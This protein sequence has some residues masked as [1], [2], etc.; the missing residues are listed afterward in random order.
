MGPSAPAGTRSKRDKAKERAAVHPN[1]EFH[2]RTKAAWALPCRISGKPRN[3]L[4]L[5]KTN[6]PLLQ[7]ERRVGRSLLRR[8][9][10]GNAAL[11]ASWLVPKLRRSSLH[12]VALLCLHTSVVTREWCLR[13]TGRLGTRANRQRPLQASARPCCQTWQGRERA[14]WSSPADIVVRHADEWSRSER[15]PLRAEERFLGVGK[16]IQDTVK[17]PQLDLFRCSRLPP[18]P[19]L[20]RVLI[21]GWSWVSG[22]SG[23]V[24]PSW[25]R[26]SCDVQTLLARDDGLDAGSLVLGIDGAHDDTGDF[27]MPISNHLHRVH[28]TG[29]VCCISQLHGAPQTQ[30]SQSEWKGCCNLGGERDCSRIHCEQGAE[31]S[32]DLGVM[33]D[34]ESVRVFFSPLQWRSRATQATHTGDP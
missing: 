13:L 34:G 10:Q 30:S 19:W 11:C 28:P 4:S 9:T 3:G 14:R 16:T 24:L 7:Q 8:P 15:S 33:L 29:P 1:I 23:Q 5:R 32:P 6:R 25:A 21:L 26:E 18:I 17:P 20:V 27:R 31:T 12:F 2:L 22:S